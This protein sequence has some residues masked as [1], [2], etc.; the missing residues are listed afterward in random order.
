MQCYVEQFQNKQECT[1]DE[2]IQKIKILQHL[3]RQQVPNGG[4]TYLKSHKYILALCMIFFFIKKGPFT[5]IVNS[6]ER[7]ELYYIIY[8]SPIAIHTLGYR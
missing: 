4:S 3:I 2:T 1:L 7:D 8:G 6:N 5:S